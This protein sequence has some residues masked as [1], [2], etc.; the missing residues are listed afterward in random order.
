MAASKIDVVAAPADPIKLPPAPEAKTV[1]PTA[2]FT[3]DARVESVAQYADEL[4][5]DEAASLMRAHI[6]QQ[7]DMIAGSRG[8]WYPPSTHPHIKK[9]ECR[10]VRL[11]SLTDT[12]RKAVVLTNLQVALAQGWKRCPP[13]MRHSLFP[14]EGDNGVYIWIWE[15][16][17]KEHDDHVREL[18]KAVEARRLGKQSEDLAELARTQGI[19]IED[20]RATPGQ[21][22]V[23]EFMRGRRA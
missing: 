19:I 5:Y 21:T 13:G 22:S 9:P 23:R 12:N 3:P 10:I 17:A 15:P 6:R 4:S 8:Q 7:R 14:L 16:L 20:V 11:G 18:R 1:E 2:S